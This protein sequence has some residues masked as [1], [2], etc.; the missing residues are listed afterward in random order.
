M[1]KLVNGTNYCECT[2]CG[3]FIGGVGTFDLHRVFIDK[4]E[5][6]RPIENW[7]R[8]RCLSIEE[9]RDKGWRIDENGYWGRPYLSA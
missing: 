1:P 5:K 6:G 2:V 8:R 7:E 4:D 9:M 3:L